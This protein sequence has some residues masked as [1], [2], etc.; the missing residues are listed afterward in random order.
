M[1]QAVT[2][3]TLQRIVLTSEFGG[4]FVL[5]QLMQLFFILS[6][7]LVVV[8]TLPDVV[9]GIYLAIIYVQFLVEFVELE[10]IVKQCCWKAVAI[11]VKC[12]VQFAKCL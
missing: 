9:H 3:L 5:T 12:L 1:L 4:G 10:V 11:Q 6:E 8:N 7:T 2:L